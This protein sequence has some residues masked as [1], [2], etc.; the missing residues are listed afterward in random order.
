MSRQIRVHK[1]D[2]EYPEGSLGLGWE[3]A[4]W[5]RDDFGSREFRW[6]Q[7]RLFLSASGARQR[8]NLLRG[9][10]A[11]VEILPSLPVEWPEPADGAQ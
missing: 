2:I 11:K 1:L 6:P 4:G 7:E 8:A 3:P 10:G 5:E 9:Y